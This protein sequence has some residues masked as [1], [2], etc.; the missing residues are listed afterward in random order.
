MGKP[1]ISFARKFQIW[2]YVAGHGQLLLRSVEAHE[3]PKRVDVLFKDVRAM[4][5]RVFIDT[6]IVEEVS[7]SDILDQMVKPVDVMESGHIIFL[8]KSRGWT[9]WIIA[10]AVYWH[11]DG[12]SFDDPSDLLLT[13][14]KPG[15]I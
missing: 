2:S 8:I 7:L 14:P 3:H 10:G 1:I 6:L 9:G 12:G 11:E 15:Q 13:P 4:N 5:L